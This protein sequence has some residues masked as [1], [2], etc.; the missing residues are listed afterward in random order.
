MNDL[1]EEAEG[2]EDYVTAKFLHTTTSN[3]CSHGWE[4]WASNYSRALESESIIVF[5]LFAAVGN[6]FISL[7]HL[8]AVSTIARQQ[9][10]NKFSRY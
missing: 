1:K 6:L 7:G 4:N 9:N 3:A 5:Q 2:A 10:K 8:L